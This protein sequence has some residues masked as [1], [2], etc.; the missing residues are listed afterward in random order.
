MLSY[1]AQEYVAKMLE[2]YLE[3]ENTV[4]KAKDIGFDRFA[5][6]ELEDAGIV[7]SY[8]RLGTVELDPDAVTRDAYPEE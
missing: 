8:P 6:K 1:V 4:F 5:W 7:K 3:D 2:T